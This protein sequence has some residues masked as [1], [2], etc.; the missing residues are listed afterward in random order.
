MQLL[1]PTS[2]RL[3]LVTIAICCLLLGFL[4]PARAGELPPIAADRPAAAA[5]TAPDVADPAPKNVAK[6][7]PLPNQYGV[8]AEYGYSFDPTPNMHSLLARVSA[9]FDYGTVWHQ[10]CPN[11]LRFKVEGAAGS[12]LNPGNNLIVSANMLAL[13]Y[14]FGLGNAF[15]PYVEAGIGVIYTEFRVQNQ[16]LHFNFNPVLG[17]GFELP[18]QNGKNLFAALRLYHLSNAEIDHENRGVN[19]VAVQ[20]GR[21]F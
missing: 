18:Q 20:V 1:P 15:R 8:M 9:V 2:V 14:P 7:E 21:F 6:K 4:S 13:K 16:G 17:A 12:T 19:S 10:D 11:T 3:S 5:G